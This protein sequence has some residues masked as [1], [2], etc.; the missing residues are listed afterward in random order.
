MQAI[1]IVAPRKKFFDLIDPDK[2]AFMNAEKLLLRQHFFQAA[3]IQTDKIREIQRQLAG[4]VLRAEDPAPGMG[5]K[6]GNIRR[7]RYGCT[8]GKPIAAKRGKTARVT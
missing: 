8:Y 7:G 5:R 4:H 1:A 6:I 2:I 3:V